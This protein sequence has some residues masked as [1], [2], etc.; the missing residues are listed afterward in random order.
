MRVFWGLFFANFSFETLKYNTIPA[1]ETSRK[2]IWTYNDIVS[3]E[4]PVTIIEHKSCLAA[5][6]QYICECVCIK[7]AHVVHLVVYICVCS[8]FIS[9]FCVSVSILK[10]NEGNNKIASGS[11]PLSQWHILDTVGIGNNL[12]IWSRQKR[13]RNINF[14]FFASLYD[15]LSDKF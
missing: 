14:H 2:L 3:F 9:S 1:R 12:Y 6:I 7:L 10:F 13:G 8:K 11:S 15:S 5:I 4:N